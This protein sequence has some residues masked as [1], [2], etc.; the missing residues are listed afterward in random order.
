MVGY[1][2][3]GFG[4]SVYIS[5]KARCIFNAASAQSA[6]AKICARAKADCSKGIVTAGFSQGS[7]IATIAKNFDSRVRATYAMGLQDNYVIYQ[8]TA[9]EP[10][11]RALPKNRLRV[12]NGIKDTFNGGS[13]ST[14][15]ESA[16]DMTGY[17]CTGLNC[18]QTDGS[19]WV[20]IPDNE[21]NDG[22]ADHCF[23]RKS[24]GC[25]GGQTAANNDTQWLSGTKAW[26]L[27]ASL[28]WLDSFVTH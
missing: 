26:A 27:P 10:G 25:V 6:I 9:S 11:N 16:I 23:M 4:T 22:N 18:L 3:G 19:G 8:N 5:N 13:E 24:G 15:R 1:A 17:T 21:V 20:L 28:A 2:S 7:V 14:G 12:A